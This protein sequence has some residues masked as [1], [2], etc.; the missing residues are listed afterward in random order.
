MHYGIVTPPVSGH[1]HPFGALGRELIARGH[2][3]TLLQMEDVRPRALEQGLEFIPLGQS[4]HPPGSLD[5]SLRELG[6]LSGMAALRFTISAICRTTGMICRDAPQAILASGIDLLLVDQTEP[7]G[8]SVAEHLSI[9]FVTICN[10]LPLNREPDIPPPFTGWSYRRTVWAR[11][12]NRLAYGIYDRFM[13]PVMQVLRTWR[14]RW[15]LPPLTDPSSTFSRL[16]QISQMTRGFDFPRE[17]L[18]AWF[19][20]TGPLRSSIPFRS[21]PFPWDQLDGR[22]LVYASLGT[23][24][25]GKREIFRSFAEAC[26]PLDVQL[27]I[28]HNGGLDATAIAALPGNPLTVAFAPQ[29]ELLSR[30]ALTLTHAGL[31]TVLDSLAAAAPIIA[32][33]IT[34][35]Q[36]AIAARVKASGAGISIPS[37]RLTP[38]A[39]EAAI[40]HVLQEASYRTQARRL[41]DEISLSGGVKAAAD[42]IENFR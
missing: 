17:Q 41:A 23:L 8:G 6:Q 37:A 40:R 39:L 15:A 9:P 16:A 10:A 36:P 28:A 11:T 14:N 4:D 2:R 32:V 29:Q 26:A 21:V 13:N 12:R 25:H 33:P 7:A 31:N 3:V 38:R 19:T 24:Q 22:P 18:P 35:E 1:I 27:V 5:R 20:Y 42:R 30:A 34:Y